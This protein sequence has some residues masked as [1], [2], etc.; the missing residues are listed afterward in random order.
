MCGQAVSGHSCNNTSACL[1]GSRCLFCVLLFVAA[2]TAA[3]S[4]AAAG[5]AAGGT[6]LAHAGG[7]CRGSRHQHACVSLG[8]C[9]SGPVALIYVATG[10]SPVGSCG[11]L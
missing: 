3:A 11:V 2:A 8:R 10:R 9:C 6:F 4:V 5:V 7:G 1:A